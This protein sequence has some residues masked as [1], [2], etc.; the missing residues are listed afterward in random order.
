[1]GIKDDVGKRYNDNIEAYFY[2]QSSQNEEAG[3]ATKPNGIG[4]VPS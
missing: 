4:Q 1:M 3:G 2:A